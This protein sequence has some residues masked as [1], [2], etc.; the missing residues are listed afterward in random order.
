MRNDPDNGGEFIQSARVSKLALDSNESVSHVTVQSTDTDASEVI[1]NNLIWATAL[2]RLKSLLVD[3]GAQSS[4]IPPLLAPERQLEFIHFVMKE[5]MFAPEAFYFYD[6]D[7]QS[8]FRL[9]NY[10]A[11]TSHPLGNA[12]TLERILPAGEQGFEHDE[13]VNFVSTFLTRIQKSS[14]RLNICGLIHSA[15]RCRTFV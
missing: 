9:T 7:P 14:E 6:L 1:R 5:P 2:P 8:A 12:Y 13:G 11:Y 3:A 10:Q 15:S 4:W